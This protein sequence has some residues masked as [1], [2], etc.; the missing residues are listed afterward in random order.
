MIYRLVYAS[1]AAKDVTHSDLHNIAQTSGCLN[2]AHG[3][4]G[5]LLW[6]E[7]NIMQILEG[8]SEEVLKLYSNIRNDARKS[9]CYV[10]YSGHF[11]EREFPNWSMGYQVIESAK[12]Q[13]YE[14]PLSQSTLKTILDN[15]QDN[16]LGSL[17]KTFG[18][19]ANI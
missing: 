7:G 15:M 8:G 5:M 10:L 12:T 6:Y 16:T 13:G 11:E 4:T 2:K 17:T 14:F 18:R 9:G 19:I 1:S 3:V